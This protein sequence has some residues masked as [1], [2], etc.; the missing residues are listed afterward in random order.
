MAEEKANLYKLF[1]ENSKL[2]S[3][4]IK[5]F[6]KSL[7]EFYMKESYASRLQ[8]ATDDLFL[9]KPRDGLMH[10]MEQRR[11]IR[12]FSEKPVSGKLLGALMSAFIETGGGHRTYA[13]GGARFPVE[14]FC[15]M[16]NVE[17]SLNRKITYY[18]C[19]NHSLSIVGDL[20]VWTAYKDYLCFDAEHG[21]PSLLFI[22]AILPERMTDKYGE[23]GGRFALIEVGHAVQNLALRIAKESMAG[24]EL[25]GLFDDKMKA[26]L[27]L[28]GTTAQIVLGYAVGHIPKK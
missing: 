17:G 21:M 12:A 23:R 1:W 14:I 2:N 8:Y 6:S 10:Y 9:K 15:F 7:E 24:V 18:N 13:S 5:E 28:D 27:K 22:F 4:N 26:M 3:S 16:N 20:P 19:D 11:S 25:G